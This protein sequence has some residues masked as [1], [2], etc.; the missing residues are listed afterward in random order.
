MSKSNFTSKIVDA[1]MNMTNKERV[2]YKD[3]TSAISIN[4]RLE[5]G[6]EIKLAPSGYYE[7]EI[8]NE[9]S[10]NKDY[11]V[12]VLLTP[13]GS[14]YYTSS[15]SFVSAFEE[16]YEELKDELFDGETVLVITT[17]KSKN[18]TGKS[19]LTCYLE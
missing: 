6:G 7:L 14:R 8:H 11:N 13:D 10:E 16:I 2:K 3:L 12:F 18:Y 19:F 5:E 17:K 15:S 4:Q 1:T 9:L